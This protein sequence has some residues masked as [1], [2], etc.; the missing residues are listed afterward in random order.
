MPAARLD[1]QLCFALYTAS[2]TVTAAYRP[3]LELHG[4][5]ELQPELNRLSKEGDWEGM[6]GLVDDDML[7]AF[8][9]VAAP[10]D[11]APRLAERFGDVVTRVSLSVATDRD[12]GRWGAL[13]AAIKSL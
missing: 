5:G 2:R 1:D 11:V 8:A 7:D 12:P 9:V 13:I 10:E 6:G 3:V 4:W